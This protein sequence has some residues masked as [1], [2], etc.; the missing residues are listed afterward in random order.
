MK[1]VPLRFAPPPAPP[2]VAVVTLSAAE[3]AAVVEQAAARGAQSVVRIQA[4]VLEELADRVAEAAGAT[5]DRWLT[6]DEAAGVAGL[7][8]KRR[9]E[10]VAKWIAEGRGQ[11]APLPARKVGRA[12]RI[13]RADLDAW[14]SGQ[15]PST[16]QASSIQPHTTE[17]E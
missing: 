7:A 4:A 10:T 12:W 16:S 14:L 1:P 17:T 8:G 6:T 15:R 2:P 5:P 11:Q 3:L 13:R 9:A